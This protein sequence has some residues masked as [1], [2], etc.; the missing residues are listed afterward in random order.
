MS[1]YPSQAPPAVSVV[2]RVR[3]ERP[4]SPGNGNLDLR[5]ALLFG[6]LDLER[7]I[8]VRIDGDLVLAQRHR[9]C[10]LANAIGDAAQRLRDLGR[11]G[12]ALELEL[13]PLTHAALRRTRPPG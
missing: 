9:E 8:P 2:V 1:P 12:G 3:V 7:E 5:L 6:R 13:P 11:R 4:T 10:P